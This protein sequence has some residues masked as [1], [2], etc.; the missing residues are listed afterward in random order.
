MRGEEADYF[1]YSDPFDLF[2]ESLEG[3]KETVLHGQQF[4]AV[5]GRIYI[6]IIQKNIPNM[7]PD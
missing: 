4:G 2:P 1:D 5:S 3:G 6:I 7:L